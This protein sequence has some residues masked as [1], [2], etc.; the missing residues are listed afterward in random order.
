MLTSGSSVLKSSKETTLGWSTPWVT[1]ASMGVP[2]LSLVALLLLST[3]CRAGQDDYV[4]LHSRAAPA[5]QRPLSFPPAEQP[6]MPAAEIQRPGLHRSGLWTIQSHQG[7][8]KAGNSLAGMRCSWRCLHSGVICR[9]HQLQQMPD[10]LCLPPSGQV[11]WLAAG[12]R[13]HLD[14]QRLAAE[15]PTVHL[16]KAAL[17]CRQPTLLK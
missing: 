9:Q 15:L 17:H 3:I 12:R 13:A 8:L 7:R 16:A 6:E 10:K 4:T 14:S 11:S 5:V 2:K 1:T